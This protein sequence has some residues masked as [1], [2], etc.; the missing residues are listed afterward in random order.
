MSE[1]QNSDVSR[2]DR[3]RGGR[4]IAAAE[5][6]KWRADDRTEL[7]AQINKVLRR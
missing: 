1:V 3:G 2:T 5:N 7:T 6:R 4:G